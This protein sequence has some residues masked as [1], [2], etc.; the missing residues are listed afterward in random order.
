MAKSYVAKR[1]EDLTAKDRKGV[2]KVL[3][4]MLDLYKNPSAWNR[5]SIADETVFVRGDEFPAKNATNFCLIGAARKANTDYEG[6][7]LRALTA[8][9][10]AKDDLLDDGYGNEAVRSSKW[11]QKH[12]YPDTVYFFNDNVATGIGD[13][14]RIIKA[15]IKRVEKAGKK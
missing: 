7:A 11:R 4:K 12:P 10:E 6:S 3:T 14:R 1:I 8:T 5:G 2:I 15:T 13:V 9:I